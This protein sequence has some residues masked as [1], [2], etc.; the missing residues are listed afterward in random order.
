MSFPAAPETGCQV[1][2]FRGGGCGR[3][4]RCHYP[5][6]RCFVTPRL[7]FLCRQTNHEMSRL[8]H[9]LNLCRS[10]LFHPFF[11]LL[12]LLFFQQLS[13]V[14]PN[15]FLYQRSTQLPYSHVMWYW[16]QQ[17]TVSGSRC[18]DCRWFGG[19]SCNSTTVI[20]VISAW[21]LS[22]VG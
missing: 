13:W 12:L 18:G 19:V 6:M 11:L 14:E 22:V 10:P 7:L 3:T 5:L 16:V 2:C 9:I 21:F 1:D 17:F 4:A 20:W 8:V 15:F